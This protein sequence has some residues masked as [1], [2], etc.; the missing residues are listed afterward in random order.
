MKEIL[1]KANAENYGVAAIMGTFSLTFY[2]G[3]ILGAIKGTK[4]Y[5]QKRINDAAMALEKSNHIY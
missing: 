5:N 2:A 4:R 1:D 3:N